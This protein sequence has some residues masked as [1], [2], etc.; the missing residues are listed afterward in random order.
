MSDDINI[1]PQL[2]NSY[3][4]TMFNPRK[5]LNSRKEHME[6]KDT[7]MRATN[8]QI[9]RLLQMRKSNMDSYQQV[10]LCGGVG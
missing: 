5:Y 10:P 1:K 3:D 4:S 6:M 2:Q 8:V 9:N 7:D